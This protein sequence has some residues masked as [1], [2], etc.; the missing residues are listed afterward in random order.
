MT[1][2]P[3]LATWRELT[4]GRTDGI[5]AMPEPFG[6]LIGACGARPPELDRALRS[7][8]VD[9]CQDAVDA[10]SSEGAPAGP[11]GLFLGAT[12]WR[13]VMQ[14]WLAYMTADLGLLERAVAGVRPVLA[15]PSAPLDVGAAALLLRG[16]AAGASGQPS[17]RAVRDLMLASELFDA[18]TCHAESAVARYCLARTLLELGMD[19]R[20]EAQAERARSMLDPVREPG[21]YAFV[22]TGSAELR[23]ALSRDEEGLEAALRLFEDAVSAA[24]RS[25]SPLLRARVEWRFAAALQGAPMAPLE[26][27]QRAVTYLTAALGVLEPAG[28]V[29]PIGLATEAATVRLHLATALQALGGSALAGAVGQY[30][31]ALRVL[32]RDDHPL[33]YALIHTN[34]ATAYLA[35]VDATAGVGERGQ[36]RPALGQHR[37]A[38]GQPAGATGHQVLAV[39]SYEEALSVYTLEDHPAE[40]AMV[41]NNLAN[42]LQYLPSAHPVENLD[43]AIRCYWAALE[44]RTAETAPLEHARTQANLAN[45]LANFPAED[46]RRSLGD[47]ARAYG[48]ALEIFRRLGCVNEALLT[49]EALGDVERDLLALQLEGERS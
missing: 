26:H 34:L 22:A 14:A 19:D 48:A 43:R 30:R 9:A 5:G 7:P 3:E 13:A 37:P 12:I 41:Q 25:L 8:G 11:E 44:I 38:L 45:A 1:V 28:A 10:L 39:Q 23:L 17:D 49:K 15:A 29:L 32:T 36:H 42:A 35:T 46:R 21:E 24:A 33:E 16:A 27:V 40:H 31:R 2:E 4:G 20:A 47:S 18:A 6:L